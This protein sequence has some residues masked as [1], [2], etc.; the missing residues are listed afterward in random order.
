MNTKQLISLSFSMVVALPGLC[1]ERPNI[2]VIFTDDQGYQDLGCFGSPLIATPNIDKMASEG[3]RLTSFYVSASVSSASRAGLLT[4]QLNSR[5]GVGGAFFPSSTGMRSDKITLAEALKE[6][7]YNTA[8]FGKWHLGDLAG[9]LPTDQGFDTFFGTPYSNDMYI[10]PEHKIASDV[11]LREGYTMAMVEG[12]KRFVEQQNRDFRRIMPKLEG[13]VPLFE[14]DEVVEF[15]CDQ[16]TLTRRYFDRAIDYVDKS[17]DEPFF[18]YITPS[19]PHIPLH[20]SAQFEG[21]SK[22][23]LYGDVVEEIDW[24]VGRLLDHLDKRGLSESTLV[25]FASDNGAWLAQGDHGG[26]SGE[27]KGGKFSIYEGGVR[28]PAI[29]RWSG[30]IPQGGVSGEISSTLD[31]FPTIMHYLGEE[32]NQRDLDGF[33]LSAHLED[34]AQ[35]S[36]REQYY[37]VLYGNVKGVREGNYKLLL[38]N[39]YGGKSSEVE[40]YDLS[41]DL[42]E[43][44]NIAAQHPDIVERLKLL[45][46]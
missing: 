41:E 36:A 43:K 16:S 14:K 8:C 23:G 25:I 40:L 6:Y 3:L 1:A 24:N 35:K 46:K 29:M 5:N 34:P 22:R 39:G 28:V 7:N 37:Y 31:I 17:G 2:I 13:I 21:H 15:P 20:V 38:G 33:N 44:N 12:Q 32:D 18:I 26:S 27:L 30:V 42:A 10:A 45:L 9:H 11:L 19:M 4:G